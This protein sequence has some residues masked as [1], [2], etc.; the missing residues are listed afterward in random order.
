MSSVVVVVVMLSMM[1]WGVKDDMMWIVF[2][3]NTGDGVGDC[4]GENKALQLLL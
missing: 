1:T 3:V 4:D 2:V